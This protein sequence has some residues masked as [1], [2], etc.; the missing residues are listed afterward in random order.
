MIM[1]R[2]TGILEMMYSIIKIKININI[3]NIKA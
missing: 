2:V 3:K 1:Y